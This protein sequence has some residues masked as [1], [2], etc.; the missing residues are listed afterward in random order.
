MS[1]T[2]KNFP[3]DGIERSFNSDVAIVSKKLTRVF[4]DVLGDNNW[5]IVDGGLW[6][7]MNDFVVFTIAPTGV[8]LHVQ[9]ATTEGELTDSPSDIAVVESIADEI[10]I[11]AGLEEEIIALDSL[12]AEIAVV[13]SEPLKSAITEITTEPLKTSVLSGETNADNAQ[14]AWDDFQDR[15][16]GSY[17]STPALSPIG[18][19][20]TDGD[21]YFNNTDSKTKIFNGSLW[22]NFGSAVNGFASN[23]EAIATAGQTLFTGL[24]YDIGF[25]MLFINGRKNCNHQINSTGM[26]C[27]RCGADAMIKEDK[28]KDA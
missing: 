5:T 27:K 6:E 24:S 9:V 20:A 1:I 4:L 18:N 7:V 8:Y 12:Q 15:Y 23:D 3:I 28:E 2:N 16:W 25:T 11:V 17:A 26:H 22:G 10:I 14:Q 13:G 19:V 21:L